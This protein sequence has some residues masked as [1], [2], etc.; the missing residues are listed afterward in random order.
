[1][2]RKERAGE[3]LREGAEV[4]DGVRD[5]PLSLPRPLSLDNGPVK[6]ELLGRERNESSFIVGRLIVYAEPLRCRKRGGCSSLVS[7]LSD[8]DSGSKEQLTPFCWQVDKYCLKSLMCS[9]VFE[10]NGLG[11]V[12]FALPGKFGDWAVSL[13]SREDRSC[14][15][16]SS[17]CK[18][19]DVDGLIAEPFDDRNSGDN[20]DDSG[21]KVCL[22]MKLI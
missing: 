2:P 15:L 9:F 6:L 10:R 13:A 1:M 21:H 17:K 22:D 3:S 12:S 11:G 5:A 20:L 14:S 7:E 18:L 19:R 4:C 8:A 16:M